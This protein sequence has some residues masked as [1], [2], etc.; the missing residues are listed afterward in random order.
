MA[1]RLDAHPSDTT[2]QGFAQGKLSDSAAGQLID[3][4]D[5]CPECRKRA[6]EL[7]DQTLVSKGA[8]L[9][10]PGPGLERPG[11]AE[12]PVPAPAAA[13]APRPTNG[14]PPELVDHPNYQ[15]VRELGRG[16]MGVVYLARNLLMDRLEVLKVMSQSMVGK[17][18]ALER[19]VQEIRSAARL[20][21]PNVA[22][23]YSAHV[24]GEQ[25][26]LAMEYVE[27]DDLGKIVKTRG[28]LPVAFSAFCAR[29][30]ALGLQRGHELGLVHRDIKPSNLILMRQG[31]RSF[32][33]IV[34]FGLAKAKAEAPSQRGLT[35]T[36]QMMGTLGYTAPEQLRDARSA[37]TRADIY[38]L[39]CTLYCLLTG[40]TPFPGSSAYEVFLAQEAG[41]VKPLREVRP[42]VPEGLATIVAKMM[43]KDAAERFLQPGDVAVAL[44]PFMKADAKPPDT[45][46]PRAAT[47]PGDAIQTDGPP[48]V[49][50]R[51]TA[52]PAN[53]GTM[54]AI[55][56]EPRITAAPARRADA[57]VARDIK[58]SD[59]PAR[60][61][62]RT[63]RSVH[64][65][66]W[67]VPTL[68]GVLVLGGATV[69]GIALS[70]RE[71]VTDATIIVENVPG[72]ADVRIDGQRA[73]FTRDGEA[74]TVTA[75]SPGPHRVVV[76][77]GSQQIWSK[78][79]SVSQGGESVRIRMERAPAATPLTVRPPVTQKPTKEPA[80]AKPS[81]AAP[82]AQAPRPIAQTEPP[83]DPERFRPPPPGP[84][85]AGPPPDP[86]GPRPPPLP[87][88]G[89]GLPPPRPPGPG[90]GPGPGRPGF[91]P[92]GG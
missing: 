16:G 84:D 53:P 21:H 72:D 10:G 34:D 33:K 83:P 48:A 86:R 46:D 71:K 67:L 11:P 51:Q 4:L 55:A 45:V 44:L 74:V 9:R 54:R 20:N 82:P 17:N 14:I 2:L 25:L 79:V 60:R 41:G 12:A 76:I 68:F 91:P 77:Q 28:A 87:P 89:S 40:L 69:A 75:L 90:P 81:V 29:E 52:R 5:E 65:R 15:V 7:P 19:F 32:V 1:T 49:D 24:M 63:N 88:R 38:S 39:G 36:N 42:E 31:K 30:A 6:A 22:T 43:A 26:V 18:D 50:P 61:I 37:D 62:K 47:P 64:S 70:L 92:P 80:R 56:D 66:T 8:S 3:H 85:G 59:G 58:R 35:A 73:D 78:E 27:G 23:A 57:R 13:P